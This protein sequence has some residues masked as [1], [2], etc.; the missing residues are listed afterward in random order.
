MEITQLA[1]LNVEKVISFIHSQ[2]YMPQYY[3]Q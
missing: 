1:G 2:A 3:F